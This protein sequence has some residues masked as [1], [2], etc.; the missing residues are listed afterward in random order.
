MTETLNQ[1]I[2]KCLLLAAFSQQ[3]IDKT[4]KVKLPWKASK[5]AVQRRHYIVDPKWW[6]WKFGL[7]AVSENDIND[8][9]KALWLRQS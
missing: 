6:S 5:T 7:I 3:S 8:F 9:K 2:E 1:N 4:V